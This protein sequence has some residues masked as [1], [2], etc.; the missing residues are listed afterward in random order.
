[1]IIWSNHA[2]PLGLL[3]LLCKIQVDRINACNFLHKHQNFLLIYYTSDSFQYSC[4][5]LTSWYPWQL[6]NIFIK[7]IHIS[8]FFILSLMSYLNQ[9]IQCK[10]G[11]STKNINIKDVTKRVSNNKMSLT[12][13]FFSIINTEYWRKALDLSVSWIF[14]RYRG[15][16]TKLDGLWFVY[17][18][19]YVLSLL[20]FPYTCQH[21]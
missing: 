15:L 10:K 17:I 3:F 1:L 18:A 7:G 14:L 4:S 11:C 19:V 8:T 9:P 2:L 16:K 20:G 21:L 12:F 6:C 13:S 5:C